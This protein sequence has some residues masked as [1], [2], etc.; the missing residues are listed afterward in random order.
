MNLNHDVNLLEIKS[1]SIQKRFLKMYFDANA[2]HIGSSL[3][4]VD[5][6]TYVFFK[7]FN[8]KDE[9]ILSKGHAAASL[10]STLC[11]YGLIKEE[12]LDTF[13]KNNTYFSA[14]PPPNKL[15]KIPFATGSLGHGL[16]L[17]AGLSLGFKLSK[18]DNKVFCVTSDGELNEGSTWEAALFIQQHKLT[19]LIWFIDR[20]KLQGFGKTEEI[21]GL[22]MLKDKLVAFGFDVYEVDGHNFN[23]FLEIP[24]DFSKFKK[25]VVIIC[26]TIKGKGW[27]NLENTVASHYL[28]IEKE[29]Y[30]NFIERI[31]SEIEELK[32]M[33]NEK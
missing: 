27:L 21:L 24:V 33:I 31:D 16:S 17:S 25:P 9:F 18:L 15:P 13:Y 2:G 30:K 29:D 5:I 10:Y 26:N 11:E 7:L 32:S 1:L 6:L 12:Q 28:P 3:S 8:I 14:H 4:C 19:N 22:D 23:E 20:N